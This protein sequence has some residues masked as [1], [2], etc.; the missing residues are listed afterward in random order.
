MEWAI[1]WSRHHDGVRS[2]REIDNLPALAIVDVAWG[3]NGSTLGGCLRP[4]SDQMA[5]TMLWASGKETKL[6]SRGAT[7]RFSQA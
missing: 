3:D 2:G 6:E 1:S 5:F 4:C 7:T